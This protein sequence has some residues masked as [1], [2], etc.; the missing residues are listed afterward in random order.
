[1]PPSPSD[2]VPLIPKLS[3]GDSDIRFMTL[4]D[5][6]KILDSAPPTFVTRELAATSAVIDGLMKVLDDTNGDVQ[7][8]ALKWYSYSFSHA[9]KLAKLDIVLAH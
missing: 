2:L 3:D 8:Q 5:L 6:K 1:M 9:L 7:S 4:V